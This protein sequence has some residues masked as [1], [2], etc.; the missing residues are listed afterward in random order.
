MPASHLHV[1]VSQRWAAHTRPKHGYEVKARL[2]HTL[3]T[4]QGVSIGKQTYSPFCD[5]DAAFAL[6][7]SLPFAVRALVEYY[8]SSQ[9][10]IVNKNAVITMLKN[11]HQAVKGGLAQVEHLLANVSGRKDGSEGL[12]DAFLAGHGVSI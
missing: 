6:F 10:L 9:M 7:R 1:Y 4:L 12:T 8:I 5:G 11:V 3:Q 2:L